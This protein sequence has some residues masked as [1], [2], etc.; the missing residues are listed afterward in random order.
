MSDQENTAAVDLPDPSVVPKTDGTLVPGNL[1]AATEGMKSRDLWQ[2]PYEDLYIIPGYNVRERT[3][4]YLAHLEWLTDQMVENGYDQT[5]PMTGFVMKVEGRDRVGVLA[6]H[7]RHEAIGRARERG[8]DIKFVPVVTTPRGTSN[9][10]LIVHLV[11]SNQGK[12]LTPYEVGTVCKRLIAEGLELSMIAKRLGISGTYVSDLLGLHEAPADVRE[13]VRSG[14]IS[15][16]LAIETLKQ[17]GGEASKVLG[18]AAEVAAAQ[19][20]TRVSAKHVA[21]DFDKAVKKQALAM[22]ELLVALRKDSGYARLTKGMQVEVNTLME[23]FPRRPKAKK[24]K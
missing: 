11:T 18:E 17:H 22:Y 2:V 21:N 10:D 24:E 12:P 19:G 5:Q 7:S 1:K 15:A 3:P 9:E 8:R 13:M 6:G 23:E 14:K 16:T 4:E 20:K